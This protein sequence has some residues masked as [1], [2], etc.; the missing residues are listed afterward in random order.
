VRSLAASCLFH[1]QFAWPA[2]LLRRHRAPHTHHPNAVRPPG[3]AG[4]H[5]RLARQRL[6]RRRPGRA[7]RGRRAGAVAR[8]RP[9]VLRGRAHQRG[10]GA[11]ARHCRSVKW[12]RRDEPRSWRVWRVDGQAA[13]R[14]TLRVPHDKMP[15]EVVCPAAAGDPSA[16]V[17]PAWG[18]HGQNARPVR[19]RTC[20]R[21]LFTRPL[22]VSDPGTR[23]LS[24]PLA[25]RIP[26]TKPPP[27]TR[28]PL[29]LSSLS[30][31][32]HPASTAEAPPTGRASE[33]VS[34]SDKYA[35][36]GE[37]EIGL[38]FG[39]RDKGKRAR[40]GAAHVFCG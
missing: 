24:P 10:A 32:L 3:L 29:S 31:P 18:L 7:P 26:A 35:V 25:L 27:A 14:G 6:R 30:L 16:F 19:H 9:P 38:V 2:P 8:G 37:F 34:S 22:N 12:R 17:A 28:A 20:K 15:S 33:A 13:R 40:A 5:V 4:L 1:C 11:H 39:P 21:S 36:I 23:A